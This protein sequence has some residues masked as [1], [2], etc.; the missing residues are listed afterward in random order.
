LLPCPSQTG[1]KNPLRYESVSAVLSQALLPPE[2][3]IRRMEKRRQNV[4]CAK[5]APQNCR[6]GAN[7]CGQKPTFS[8]TSVACPLPSSTKLVATGP[9]FFCLRRPLQAKDDPAWKP[10]KTPAPE[11]ASRFHF[12]L[13]PITDPFC[14]DVIIAGLTC[15]DPCWVQYQ[16]VTSEVLGKDMSGC[17]TYAPTDAKSARLF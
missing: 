3:G 12:P 11:T 7:C 6:T 4:A 2:W 10:R 5:I 13:R 17:G 9:R 14:A 16:R 1:K 8:L 15:G